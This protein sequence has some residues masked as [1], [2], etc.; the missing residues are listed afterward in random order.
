MDEKQARQLGYLLGKKAAEY[1]AKKSK[2]LAKTKSKV[3]A[4]AKNLEKEAKEARVIFMAF[5]ESFRAG[6]KEKPSASKK[7]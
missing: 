1:S 2:D 5:Q 3:K 6:F 7:K 4:T